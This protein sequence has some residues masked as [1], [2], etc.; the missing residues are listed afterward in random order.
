MVATVTKQPQFIHLRLAVFGM[1]QAFRQ[2]Q[3]T[4]FVGD[5]GD[6]GFP[7]LVVQLHHQPFLQAFVRLR[8][9]LQQ[10]CH[11]FSQCL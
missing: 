3:D 5:R 8:N 7:H 11:L 4:T 9:G 1:A 2:Q 10:L 6:G